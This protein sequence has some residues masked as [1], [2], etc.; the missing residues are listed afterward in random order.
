MF[1]MLGMGF[2][3]EFSCRDF[4]SIRLEIYVYRWVFFVN[5]SFIFGGFKAIGEGVIG[6][7]Y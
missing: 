2:L 6:A 4:D 1:V 7:M 3:L 5:S